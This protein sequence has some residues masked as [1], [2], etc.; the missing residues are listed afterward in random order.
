[1]SLDPDYALFVQIAQRGSISA[2]ARAMGISAPMASKRLMR[3]EQR[4]G[5][6]LVY[7]TTRRV[8]LTAMGE[9]FYEDVTAI[10]NAIRDAEARL[11]GQASEL[12]GR[13]RVNAPTSFGRLHI[14]PHL[15]AFL[16]RYP[17]IDMELDLSDSFSDLMADDLDLAIR[18]AGTLPQSLASHVLAPNHRILCAA[19]AYIAEHG[20][21]A[22]LPDLHDHRL[23]AAK[24]QSP[25]Q[26]S[27]PEGHVN[28]D[29]KSH[30]RTNSSEVVRELA[31]AGMGIA[32]RS[33][34]DISD[35]LAAGRLVRI[36]DDYEGTSN[37]NVLAVHFATPFVPQRVLAF[38]DFLRDLY[39]PLPPWGRGG[40]RA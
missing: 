39:Q 6:S 2:A 18:I 19:P 14:A 12:S 25:W 36:L 20:E 35:A 29:V 4:L 24:G 13:L 5:T 27:G 38:I 22:T 32:L 23:L 9:A 8:A 31:E 10:L 1:M 15:G 11:T 37:I 7:R 17:A 33:L 16:T 3:L 28:V 40:D 21:P 34:W 30:V 26:L